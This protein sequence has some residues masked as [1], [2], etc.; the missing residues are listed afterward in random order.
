LIGII[1]SWNDRGQATWNKFYAQVPDMAPPSCDYLCCLIPLS[2]AAMI[3]LALR[4][5]VVAG[6]CWAASQARAQTNIPDDARSL[7][8]QS[9]MVG[10]RGTELRLRFDRPIS[11]ERSWLWII[12][13][14]RIVATVHFRLEAEPSV[15]FARIPTPS[16]GAYVAR[17]STCPEG[18]NDR[19]EGEF[20]F[21]VSELDVSTTQQAPRS[22]APGFV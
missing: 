14:G 1:P 11:H 4:I 18:T 19:Y 15:L 17:W 22:S 12:H 10:E 7:A 2:E 8:L 16:P 5:L 20:P 13:D 21:L 6:L 3:A 9:V